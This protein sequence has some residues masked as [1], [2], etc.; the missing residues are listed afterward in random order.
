VHGGPEF[1]GGEV[2]GHGGK[3]I[4]PGRRSHLGFR[5]ALITPALFSQPSTHPDGEKRE[6]FVEEKNLNGFS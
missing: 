1:V 4:V 6:W 3:S 2:S 5:V